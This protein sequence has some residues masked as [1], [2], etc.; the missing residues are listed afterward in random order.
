MFLCQIVLIDV[1][2]YIHT[3]LFLHIHIYIFI[4]PYMYLQIYIFIHI[5]YERTLGKSTYCNTKFDNRHKSRSDT[6]F[7]LHTLRNCVENTSLVRMDVNSGS[8]IFERDTNSC[9]YLFNF[10]LCG[11]P[12]A[13]VSKWKC[14]VWE[15]MVPPAVWPP[16][17][18]FLV[19][20]FTLSSVIC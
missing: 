13:A 18:R 3:Y 2:I 15:E 8:F 4:Y 6:I 11:L 14:L 16:Q 5:I 10:W 7:N 17:S 1:K 19:C 12:S 20:I 9:W